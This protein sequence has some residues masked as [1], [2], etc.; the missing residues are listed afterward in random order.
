MTTFSI[1]RWVFEISRHV[2]VMCALCGSLF[3]IRVRGRLGLKTSFCAKFRSV[4]Y[5]DIT[6]DYE[7]TRGSLALSAPALVRICAARPE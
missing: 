6:D 7:A 3:R 1:G 4:W 2:D 5:C